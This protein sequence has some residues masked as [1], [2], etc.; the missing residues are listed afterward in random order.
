M[1]NALYPGERNK[2]EQIT[3][4]SH[5]I[6]NMKPSLDERYIKLLYYICKRMPSLESFKAF[7]VN[8][9]LCLLMRD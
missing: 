6:M 2:N 5:Q 1:K 7:E 4:K 3:G 8:K 9:M